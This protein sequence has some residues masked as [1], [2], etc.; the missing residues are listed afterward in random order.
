MNST[1]FDTS[2]EQ[3]D[4]VPNAPD[5]STASTKA[6][7]PQQNALPIEALDAVLFDMDG[8]VT[9]TADAH[10]SAW[11]Q[12]FDEYFA[13]CAERQR[14]EFEPFDADAEYKRYVDGKPRYDGVRSVLRARGIDLEYGSP[15]DDPAKETVCGLGNRKNERFGAWLAE[16]AVR[17]YPSTLEVVRTLRQR[18]L[19]VAV[20]T[21]SRNG[22]AV[23]R[24]AKVLDR[25]DAKVDGNDRKR[26]D[27]KGKPDP[28]VLLEAARRVGVE[29][30]RA[31]VV[32][33]SLAGVEAARAGG[34]AFVI[35]IDRG[36]A[37][38]V[39]PARRA[40]FARRGADVVVTDL[41]QIRL[42]APRL[43]KRD[44]ACIDSVW[45]HEGSLRERITQA[46][47]ALFFDF[48][49]TLTP[50]VDDPDAA[51]L[52]PATRLK[53][54]KLAERCA[55][56]II[57]GRDLDD[58]RRRIDLGTVHLAGSHGFDIAGP[59]GSG[60]RLQKGQEFVSDLDETEARLRQAFCDLS[61]VVVE[62]KKF[63]IAVH[64][65][66]AG[67]EDAAR[68]AASIGEEVATRKRLS[69]SGGKKVF[70]IQPNVDWHKGRAVCW[71][72]REMGLDR[73]GVLPLYIGDDTTDEDAFE[74]LAGNG[75]AIVVRDGESN[76]SL[77]S[78]T[79]DDTAD[80][81]RLLDRLLVWTEGCP[82]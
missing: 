28:A 76:A 21:A 42:S 13:L 80:V 71:L 67:Q 41:E 32:E 49:G 18:G 68:I 2:A 35:G 8:V 17:T 33:D 1:R 43:R 31:G 30:A 69:M 51:R 57:S 47:P 65:R 20:F 9:D 16:N 72:L 44:V 24:N 60:L 61:G 25:F 74:A 39:D 70:Q 37:E 59:A 45:A 55:L 48:D 56:G 46:T 23:L 26:L 4:T 75:I 62:R 66:A 53:L 38:T 58:L 50:I 11:K 77:A 36:S 79:L 3:D 73:P 52:A 10:A 22:E 5:A 64:H 15:D 27:L 78:Y 12:M 63:S 40:D 7:G 29:P 82:K 54:A 34:F 14:I 81:E 19:R 6:S